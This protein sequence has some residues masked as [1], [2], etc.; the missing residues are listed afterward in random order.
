MA[1]SEESLYL[2]DDCLILIFKLVTDGCDDREYSRYLK[3]LSSKSKQLLSITNNFQFSLT[4]YTAT[5]PYP[6]RLFQRFPNLTSPNLSRCY[7]ADIPSFHRE[8]NGLLRKI[9]RLPL[10]LTSLNI[11]NKAIIPASG[12]RDLSQNITTLTSL[13]CSNILSVTS[14]HM[15]L[16]ADCFP[17]LEELDLSRR[18]RLIN[19]VGGVEALSLALFKL[20]RVNLSGHEY[21]NDKLLLH[22]FKNC[23]LLEEA[24]IFRC[25]QLTRAGMASALLERPTLRSLSFTRYFEIH[26]HALFFEFIRNCPSLTEIKVE[27]QC[28]R[29]QIAEYPNLMNFVLNPQLKSL[30][31]VFNR[32]L[33]NEK[34]EAFA[35]SFPNPI[36][37]MKKVF[38]KFYRDVVRLDI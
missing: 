11:S 6:R 3:S 14:T 27:Y 13:T 38:V 15:F 21:I 1:S 35:S 33:T 5:L 8:L 16:I 32:W 7:T 12:L 10:K 25:R 37:C 26:E 36:T 18:G 28:G 20:R 30:S 31:L 17:L 24:I 34:M 4:I 22:L 9:S 19:I 2:P 23:K 29:V